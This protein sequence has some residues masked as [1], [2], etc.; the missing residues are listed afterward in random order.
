[1]G[2]TEWTKDRST[3]E[4]AER[5]AAR[6]NNTP[7]HGQAFDVGGRRIESRSSPDAREVLAA[8]HA[9][10]IR[11]LCLCTGAGVPMYVARVGVDRFIVKRMP[12]TGITHA[13]ACPS[14]LPPESL[15]GLGQ[16]LGAAILVQGETG[17]TVLRLGF[18][19]AT[20]DRNAPGP[21]GAS[22]GGGDSV[23]ADGE[24]LSLRAVLH[25]LWQEADLATWSP[26]MAGKRNW[27]VVSWHLRQA[28]QGKFTKG[29]PLMSRLYIPEPFQADRKAELTARR[30]AAWAPARTKPRTTQL[31]ILIGELKAL[32]SARF[33]HKLVI[34][35]MPDTPLILHDD[36]H[37]RFLKRFTDEI[38]MWQ[39]DEQGHLIVIATFSVG[40]A[41]LASVQEL[42][43][44]MTDEHWLPYESEADKLLL[45]SAISARRRFTKSLRYNLGADRPMPSLVFTDTEVPT[46]AYLLA[47]NDAREVIEE[48]QASRGADTWVW[49]VG[50]KMPQFPAERLVL[51]QQQLAASGNRDTVAV[52]QAQE[53][54]RGK[55]ATADVAPA[56]APHSPPP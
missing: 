55:A 53:V 37:R 23:T 24:R 49:V 33:G 32:E 2:G 35:H 7:A 21:G 10:R 41:G 15:S 31:M 51:S 45:D 17:V 29:K 13:V 1:M 48:S 27:R 26:G 30:I 16:V 20:T 46:A 22:D 56:T 4:I 38:E 28:A 9:D 18:R 6:A 43:V 47:S 44:A 25:Y 19:M 5:E 14:Y 12:D 52:A 39:A 54:G 40:R 11:P 42:S 36:L 3:I 50:E 34:K 8:A